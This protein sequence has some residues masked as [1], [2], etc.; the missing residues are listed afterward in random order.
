[1]PD[2][3]YGG[4]HESELKYS[5]DEWTKRNGAFGYLI[6]EASET[7]SLVK[8]FID[9]VMANAPYITPSDKR[10]AVAYGYFV[11]LELMTVEKAE[12][13]CGIVIAPMTKEQ[14]LSVMGF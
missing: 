7:D 13:I 2:F 3:I 11:N 12:E 9:K 5:H 8:Y 6:V 10:L 4:Q 1:M 14:V